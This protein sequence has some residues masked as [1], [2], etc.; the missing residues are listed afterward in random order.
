MRDRAPSEPE[1]THLV[2]MARVLVIAHMQEAVRAW[3]GLRNMLE[4]IDGIR[5]RAVIGTTSQVD[6][7]LTVHPPE[8][9]EV[10]TG[11]VSDAKPK[12]IDDLP[13]SDVIVVTNRGLSDG[14]PT[15]VL[16]HTQIL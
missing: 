1:Y 7:R 11:H 10:G 14:D 2:L 16:E 9:E 12:L 3:S 13:Q 4:Q 15:V 5:R 8:I 6:E